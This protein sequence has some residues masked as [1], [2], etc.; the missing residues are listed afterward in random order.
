MRAGAVG[1]GRRTICN[2]VV[3]RIDGF[4]RFDETLQLGNAAAAVRA[5]AAGCADAVDRVGTAGDDRRDAFL[6]DLV[7]DAHDRALVGAGRARTIRQQRSP[8]LERDA[9]ALELRLEPAERGQLRA[10][11]EDQNRLE[12]VLFE[13]G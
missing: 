10:A 11:T 8:L 3:S 2:S 4:P 9:I 6:A 7:A 12:A 13:H 5:R 1:S